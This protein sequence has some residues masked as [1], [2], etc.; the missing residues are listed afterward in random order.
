M[1]KFPLCIEVEKV[2]EKIVEMNGEFLKKKCLKKLIGRLLWMHSRVMKYT[3]LLEETDS[4]VLILMNSK[5][6]SL[7][8]LGTPP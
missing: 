2:V 5:Q 1:N 4:S 7:F 3:K 8:S 6:V